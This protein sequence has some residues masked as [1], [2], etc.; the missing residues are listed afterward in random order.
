MTLNPR[1]VVFDMDGTLTDSQQQ[2]FCAQANRIFAE[3]SLPQYDSEAMKELISEYRFFD[4]LQEQNTAHTR[5]RFWDIYNE[6]VEPPPARVI[7]GARDAIEHCLDNGAVVAIATARPWPESQVRKHLDDTALL[8]QISVV[9]TWHGKHK[10]WLNKGTQL[11]EICEKLG[12]DPIVTAMVGDLPTDV[13]SAYQAGLGLAISVLTGNI[14]PDILSKAAGPSQV[15]TKHLI[16]GTVA[17][18]KHHLY[19]DIG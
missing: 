3:M 7:P 17:E 6:S 5:N 11:L 14:K 19:K 2:E 10:E 15:V 18:I 16:M 8:N 13:T 9:S 1:L 12:I 4:I